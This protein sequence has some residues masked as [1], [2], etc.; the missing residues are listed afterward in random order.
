MASSGCTPPIL[1][2]SHECHLKINEIARFWSQVQHSIGMRWMQ[3]Q[4]SRREWRSAASILDFFRSLD[5]TYLNFSRCK[6]SSAQKG[7]LTNL[8]RR[9]TK[10]TEAWARD[11]FDCWTGAHDIT[12][13]GIPG[14]WVSWKSCKKKIWP[15][16]NWADLNTWNR[17]YEMLRS[18]V[19]EVGQSQN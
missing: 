18:Q 15:L 1:D 14:C 11:D 12:P 5:T 17:G 16:T 2:F 10:W 3:K 7:S 19:L 6:Y 8:W 9:K 13:S 4:N